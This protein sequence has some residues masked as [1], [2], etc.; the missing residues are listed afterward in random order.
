M[1]G[2]MLFFT[3]PSVMNVRRGILLKKLPAGRGLDWD[4]KGGSHV[5]SHEQAVCRPPL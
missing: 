3:L 2:D 4:E 1:S 5:R